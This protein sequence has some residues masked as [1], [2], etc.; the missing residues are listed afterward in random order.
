MVTDTRAAIDAVSALDVIDASRIYLVGYALGGKV[1][2][3]TAALDNRV[4][5]IAALCGFDPLRL[6]TPE[7]GAEGIRHY[8]HLH[9]L[10]PRLGFFIGEESRLPFDY[11]QVLALIAPRPALLIAPTLDRYAPVD[12]VKRE[13]EP[14]RAIY[15]L[16]GK[17]GALQLETPLDFNEFPKQRQERIFDWIALQ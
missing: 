16:L 1:G 6:D 9:G 3:L 8:S 7:K 17:E 10:I 15:R 12:D 5:A 14:A 4:K 11:D 13:V 2:L